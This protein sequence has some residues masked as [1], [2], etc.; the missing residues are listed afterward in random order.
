MNEPEPSPGR[1]LGVGYKYVA[2]GMQFAGGIVLFMAAGWGLD[3]WLH[4]TPVFTI[5]GT[6]LGGV[7]SFLSVYRRLQADIQANKR[8]R[9]NR[10]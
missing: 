3:R 10:V 4:L 6:L 8:D 9:G 1:E 5:A 7:L 2:M